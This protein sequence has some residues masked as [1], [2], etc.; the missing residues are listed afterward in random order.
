M[1]NRLPQTIYRAKGI[2]FLADA[3]GQKGV[4]QVVGKRASLTLTQDGWQN[5]APHSQLVVIGAEGT[6]DGDDLNRRMQACLAVN[7]PKSER[8]YITRTVVEW[9]R[10]RL[11]GTS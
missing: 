4:L 6:V 2:F 8:E 1:V 10:Q 11:P 7:A 3:T 5:A 9:L